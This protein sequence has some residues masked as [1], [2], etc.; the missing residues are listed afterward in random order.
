MD[1]EIVEKM[2]AMARERDNMGV[3]ESEADF[4]TGAMGMY[5]ALK[6]ESEKDGS[7]CPP[8][9]LFTLM[10]GGSIIEMRNAD[11]IGDCEG[12]AEAEAAAERAADAAAEIEAERC[13]DDR[14][15][16]FGDWEDMN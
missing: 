9:W 8:A 12:E 1:G 10:G 7:W 13:Y 15:D 4:F 3:L 5:L 16:D 2:E 6:P 11:D 14:Y